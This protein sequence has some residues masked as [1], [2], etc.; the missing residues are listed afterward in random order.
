MDLG[1]LCIDSHNSVSILLHI[2]SVYACNIRAY[3][4]VK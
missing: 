2:L 1:S 3:T 4:M